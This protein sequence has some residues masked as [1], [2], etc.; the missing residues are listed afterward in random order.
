MKNTD[1]RDPSKRS[2]AA[3]ALDL[4]EYKAH[5]EMIEKQGET[6]LHYL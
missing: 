3:T 1:W 5:Q 4:E 6:K 2:R